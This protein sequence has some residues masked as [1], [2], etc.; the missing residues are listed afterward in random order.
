MRHRAGVESLAHELMRMPV[1]VSVEWR[2]KRVTTDPPRYAE[3][4]EWEAAIALRAPG[5][6]R[7]A[8]LL[9]HGNETHWGLQ[10][11]EPAAELEL[12]AKFFPWRWRTSEAVQVSF[13]GRRTRVTDA[14]LKQDARAVALVTAPASAR[15]GEITSVLQ[16]PAHA[17]TLS[18]IAFAEGDTETRRLHRW[19][20][21]PAVMA[22]LAERLAPL[23]SGYQSGTLVDGPG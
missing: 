15:T 23:A 11:D 13:E 22:Q 12:S 14:A 1:A 17:I 10:S 3:H 9:T 5:P 18:F 8:A 2:S 20:V 19:R 7:V 16:L 4:L 21:K 6:M